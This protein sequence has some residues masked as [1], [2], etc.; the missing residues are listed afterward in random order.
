MAKELFKL[1]YF[2]QSSAAV[3]NKSEEHRKQKENGKTA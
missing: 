3:G 2:F 1:W